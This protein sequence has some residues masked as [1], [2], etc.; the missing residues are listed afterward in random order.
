MNIK[1]IFVAIIILLVSSCATRTP[2]VPVKYMDTFTLTVK[3]LPP[4]L[5]KPTCILQGVPVPPDQ[6]LTG[7]KFTT[8]GCSISRLS[9]KECL[10]IV[11]DLT[12]MRSFRDLYTWGEEVAHCVYLNLH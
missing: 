3:T 1:V 4:K 12:G 6:V 8:N 2:T 9:T 7:K 11:P 5:I 10:I